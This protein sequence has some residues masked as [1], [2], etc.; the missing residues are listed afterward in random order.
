M[1]QKNILGELT[2]PGERKAEKN[3]DKSI[4][5]SIED[6]KITYPA[7]VV[8]DTGINRQTVFDRLRYLSKEG[9]IER[10]ALRRKVPDELKGR[11]EEL[12]DLGLKG[13]MIRRMS[14]YKLNDLK[15]EGK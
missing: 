1:E 12:W 5:E 7:E 14:W 3:I 15:E 11:L 4:L 6:R 8:G 10:V 2:P 9:K 13:Q